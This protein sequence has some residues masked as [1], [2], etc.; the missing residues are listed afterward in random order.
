MSIRINAAAHL[1]YLIQHTVCRSLLSLLYIVLLVGLSA[2]Q[3]EKEISGLEE[4][5]PV[6]RELRGGQS[7]SYRVELAAGQFM[8]AIVEQISVDVS[9]KVFDPNGQKLLEVDN[10]N[11][12]YGLESASLIAETPGRYL[13]EVRPINQMAAGRYLMRLEPLHAVTAKDR[14]RL[15]AERGFIEAQ[16]LAKQAKTPESQRVAS[17]RLEENLSLWRQLGGKYWEAFTLGS[18]AG[19]RRAQGQP[20]KALALLNQALS[21][22][23]ALGNQGNKAD[24]LYDL[25]AIQ[26]DRN[27]N[28]LALSSFNE[29]LPIWQTL[30]ESQTEAYTHHYL[31]NIYLKTQNYP[32]AL[33]HQNQALRLMRSLKNRAGEADT[34]RNIGVVYHSLR[35]VQ[36]AVE[37]YNQ[38]LAYWRSVSDLARQA[39]V[40]D[41]I[42]RV[43]D[44]VDDDQK[45]IDLYT[46]ALDLYRQLKDER[47]QAATL[48]DLGTTYD[49][50]GD[51]QKALEVLNQALTLRQALKDTNGI[52]QTL[53]YIGTVYDDLND[54][55]KTVEALNEALPL[56]RAAGN[57]GG[58][59]QTLNYLGD[60]H[61]FLGQSEQALT[62]YNSALTIRHNSND[63][64]GEADTLN[65]IGLLYIFTSEWQKALNS[66]TRARTISKAASYLDG[67]ALSLNGLGIVYSSLE[68]YPQ[69]LKYQ[70]QA[71]TLWRRTGDKE[72]EA[73]TLTYLSHLYN[74][75]GQSGRAAEVYEQASPLID[76]WGKEGAEATRAIA[77]GVKYI[78]EDDYQKAID[79][80]NRALVVIRAAKLD[81]TFS[82]VPVFIGLSY[83]KLDEDQ[84]ALEQFTTSLPVLHAVGN[85]GYEALAL[86]GIAL[87]ERDRGNFA[88][89]RTRIEAALKIVESLRGGF[90]NED[91]RISFFA[92]AQDY[93]ELYIDILMRLHKQEPLAGH[94]G[95]AFQASELGRARSLLDSLNEAKADIRQGVDPQL[96]KRE[97]TLW[98]Q[99]NMQARQQQL[100]LLD[101][102]I[103]EKQMLAANDNI[104]SLTLELQQ[105]RAEIREKSPAYA[106]LTQ[107]QP[108]TL[109]EIQTQVLDDETV[110]LEYSLGQDRSFLWVVTP[111]GIASYELPRRRE[112]DTAAR[113]V[114]E[115]LNARA[116]VI[117]GETDAQRQQRITRADAEYPVASAHLSRMILAPAAQQLGNKRLLIVSHRT[118]QYIPFGALPDPAVNG[119]SFTPLILKHE[120]VSVLSAST[121]A[122]LRSGT[123]D[124]PLAPHGV[125]VLADPVFSANDERLQKISKP[126]APKA[127]S[128]KPTPARTSSRRPPNTRDIT[129]DQPVNNLS[130]AAN[131]ALPIKRLPYTRQEAD[132]I[133]KVATLEES[134]KAFDFAAN[135]Q[136]VTDPRLSRYRYVHF[137]THGFIN[138]DHPELSGIVLSMIN[139]KGTPQDGFLR[140]HEIFNLKLPAELVVLSACQTGLGKEIRGEGLV[141]LTRGFMYAG[142]PRVV[143][144]LWSV[145]D[146]ATAELMS[147][148]Y[149]GILKEKMRPAAALRAAQ[150]SLMKEGGWESPFYWA[151]FTLQGEWK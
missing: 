87:I 82:F 59:S 120:I 66:F 136:F 14:T 81:R 95:E 22:Y 98:Q 19:I 73:Q 123:R 103:T 113:K 35:D 91:L 97:Q 50:I 133:L 141:G 36:K 124:R 21:I 12:R 10:P 92:S 96:V 135:R 108:L 32:Q 49:E 3:D 74:V 24:T 104:A 100:Q 126:T 148:F 116:H 139:D 37:H 69:A 102:R 85:R 121:L 39:S 99:L 2:G 80:F 150:I 34:L 9:I 109:K 8:Q 54:E 63:Q 111:T 31:G 61:L 94:D 78:A 45:A 25:G 134:I 90:A 105:V 114:Y 146:R 86:V 13:L 40:L 27:E 16:Q 28:T 68:N 60:V 18:I 42:A 93:F 128:R 144:S 20:D 112:I 52:A 1:S 58:E 48:Y 6:Q 38:A 129:H 125:A 140:A 23:R 64:S 44:Y 88:A 77:L 145:S 118:L 83:Y 75:M 110:L 119:S 29:A 127:S 76:K 7:H 79:A 117:D 149:R 122:L 142:A 15:A 5:K 143:V 101:G 4:G 137:A 115:L 46:Q 55:T 65:D 84:K 33:D 67:E 132:E 41:D 106:A 17:A 89:A 147:R 138:S 62:H 107:P 26:Y 43:Y 47:K 30:G 131:S 11:S 53:Y 151:A 57:R 72:G 70:N 130:A 71:L 51:K 56:Y